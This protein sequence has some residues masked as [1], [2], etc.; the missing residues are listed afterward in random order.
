M[1]IDNIYKEALFKSTMAFAYHKAIYD[2]QGKMVDYLFLDVNPAFEQATGLKRKEVLGKQYVR[3][4]TQHDGD[5]LQWVERYDQV[6]KTQSGRLFEEYSAILKSHF[7]VNVYPTSEDTFV[8]LF[9]NTSNEYKLERIV[10]YFLEHVDK[11]VDYQLINKI[12]LEFAGADFSIFNVYNDEN[13]FVTKSVLGPTETLDQVCKILDF[14]LIDKKWKRSEVYKNISVD[15]HILQFDDISSIAEGIVP[16]LTI[17]T[18]KKLFNLGNVVIAEIRKD[19]KVLGSFT[20]V[21]EKESIFMSSSYL[22][23]YF[24]QLASFLDKC[25]LER[26]LD[27][28]KTETE[29]MTRRLRRDNLTNSYNRS[30]INTLLTDRLHVCQHHKLKSA[31]AVLDI[32][33]FK[34]INDSYGHEIGDS[35]LKL[36]VDRINTML[37]SEDLLIRIGGDE[38]LLYFDGVASNDDVK[39]ILKRI[40]NS[41]AQPFEVSDNRGKTTI[42]IEI[43]ISAGVALFPEDGSNIKDLMFKA[44]NTM[45]QVKKTGKNHF[46]FFTGIIKD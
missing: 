35:V 28:K 31:V 42:A 22:N 44:D 38:F 23:I 8:T 9:T 45:Y 11:V 37:R 10:T 12:A 6:L 15:S 20:F 5:S 34:T 33:N 24:K 14:K 16:R 1:K 41:L 26:T 25:E 29:D 19:Q 17:S 18:I 32:D 27:I 7:F 4:I 36:F 3:D 13:Y 43:H 2:D 21:F 30:V 46:A 40:F 39:E